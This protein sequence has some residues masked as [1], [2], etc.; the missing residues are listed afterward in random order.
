MPRDERKHRIPRIWRCPEHGAPTAGHCARC[1][2]ITR[3][4]IDIVGYGLALSREQL[5]LAAELVIRYA[6][7]YTA[8]SN[9]NLPLVLAARFYVTAVPL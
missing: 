3:L 2:S 8:V 5:R 6:A 7:N 9:T 1:A 4:L